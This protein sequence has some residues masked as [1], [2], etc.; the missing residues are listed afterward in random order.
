MV[1]PRSILVC[2]CEDTMPLDAKALCE[3]CRSGRLVTGRQFCRTEFQR[4]YALAAAGSPLTIGCTQEAPRFREA[5]GDAADISFVNLRETAG[6]SKDAANAGPKMAALVAAAAEPAPKLAFVTL[7]SEGII[8]VY[9][10]DE[11]A[12]EAAD[13][14]KD[15]LDVTVVLTR[16]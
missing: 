12:V 1:N 14:L 16:P 15:H 13:L 2:S 10:R 9:G 3:G 7:K 4:F 8:L 11:R 5:A 6:W